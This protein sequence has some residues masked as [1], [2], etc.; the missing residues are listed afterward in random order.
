MT[1]FC[2]S[3]E[4]LAPEMIR[5]LPKISSMGRKGYG[6]EIDIWAVGII[7]FAVLSGELPFYETENVTENT[8]RSILWNGITFSNNWASKSVHGMCLEN[9]PDSAMLFV[10][11]LLRKI[12]SSR[13]TASQALASH[14]LKQ[15]NSD[16]Q[17][18]YHELV[19][20]LW[21]RRED[22]NGVI[23][24]SVGGEQGSQEGDQ[25][26]THEKIEAGAV[27]GALSEKDVNVVEGKERKRP[28]P[29]GKE[30]DSRNLEDEVEVRKRR[31]QFID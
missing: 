1:S 26:E 7:S 22:R 6:K 13:P 15:D 2:G 27:L 3:L 23:L 28:Y 29:D 8:M 16:L 12:P 24:E 9:V 21:N 11:G 20:S 17:S 18:L 5:T 31:K 4:F 25:S 14:F 30:N 10:K 19:V